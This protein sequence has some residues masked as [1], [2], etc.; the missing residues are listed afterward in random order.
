MDKKEY[1]GDGVYVVVEDGSLV[2]TT[3][4]G[5]EATNTIYLEK[6]VIQSLLN[7]INIIENQSFEHLLESCEHSI[8]NGKT[9]L[10]CGIAIE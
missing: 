2:L 4:N 7:Y 8:D 3:E 1:L 5:I 6:V 10:P 9:W